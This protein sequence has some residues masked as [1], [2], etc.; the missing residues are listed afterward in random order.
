MSSNFTSIIILIPKRRVPPLHSYYPTAF[1]YSFFSLTSKGDNREYWW[2]GSSLS[3]PP[4]NAK[5]GGWASGPG[6]NEK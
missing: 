3:R 6:L 2:V 5:A 1:L 4:I